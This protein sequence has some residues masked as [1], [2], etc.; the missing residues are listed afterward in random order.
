MQMA[1]PPKTSQ[2][3]ISSISES[4]HDRLFEDRSQAKD[5]LEDGPAIQHFYI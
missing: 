4:G 5:E 2:R 1:L 3:Q